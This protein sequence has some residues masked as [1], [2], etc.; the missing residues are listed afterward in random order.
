MCPV[1]YFKLD[2]S[3]LCANFQVTYDVTIGDML[4]ANFGVAGLLEMLKAFVQCQFK[5]LIRKASGT[6]ALPN[7]FGAK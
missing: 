1:P 3:I 5:A 7:V 2:I 6:D 4:H